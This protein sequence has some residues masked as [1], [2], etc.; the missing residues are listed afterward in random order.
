MGVN[1]KRIK[2]YRVYND[3]GQQEMADKLGIGLTSYCHRE[4][5]L[6]EFT[7]TEVSKMAEIFKV[8][9]GDLFSRDAKL[10]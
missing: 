8:D 3:I 6:K 10:V 2:A 7:S 4:Q 5:G 9:P 1:L